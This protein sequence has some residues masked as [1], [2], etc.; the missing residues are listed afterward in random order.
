VTFEL[1]RGYWP[2]QRD[3]TTGIRD[4]LNNVSK[5]VVSSTLQDPQWQHTTVLRGALADEIQ[6]LKSRPGTDIVASTSSAPSR[7]RSSKPH[8]NALARVAR[9][10][11]RLL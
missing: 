5:Y 6:T 10:S 11:R 8:E 2:L 1:F 9:R 7:A 3:D 4:Y